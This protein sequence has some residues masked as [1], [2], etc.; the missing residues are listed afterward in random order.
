MMSNDYYEDVMEFVYTIKERFYIESVAVNISYAP[1][2]RIWIVN[3]G[4]VNITVTSILI[5]GSGESY[6]YSPSDG[7]I[8]PGE[9]VVL[10]V[11]PTPVPLSENTRV[12][13]K[14]ESS[15]ENKAYDSVRI[16]TS[17]K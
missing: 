12:S 17:F 1:S 9:T 8:A 11:N 14:V 16:P 6:S 13:I 3:Y 7:T 4:G 10:D 5:S 2:L 15:R